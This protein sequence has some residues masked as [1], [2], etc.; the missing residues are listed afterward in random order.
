MDDFLPTCGWGEALQPYLMDFIN[1]NLLIKAPRKLSEETWQ[2]CTLAKDLGALGA[3]HSTL[4][5]F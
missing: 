3:T 1:E 5:N 2:A 4:F